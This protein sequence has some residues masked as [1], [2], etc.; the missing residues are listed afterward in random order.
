MFIHLAG[1]TIIPPP[2][3]LGAC[4]LLIGGS[5][6]LVISIVPNEPDATNYCTENNPVPR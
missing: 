1:R 2:T 4:K 3:P 5:T 6:L